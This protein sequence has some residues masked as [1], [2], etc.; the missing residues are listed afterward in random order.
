MV[1]KR[2]V[3][4]GAAA[5]LAFGTLE[6]LLYYYFSLGRLLSFCSP[7]TRPCDFSFFR[8]T[9]LHLPPPI[10][11]AFALRCSKF[12]QSSLCHE[13]ERACRKL[14]N[15]RSR[16][17]QIYTPRTRPSQPASEQPPPPHAARFFLCPRTNR[18][19][20]VESDVLD[21]LAR[22]RTL[23]LLLK[24]SRPTFYINL[25]GRTEPAL[26]NELYPSWCRTKP[27]PATE[28]F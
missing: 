25:A 14:N 24:R 27:T 8:F 19:W 17:L 2:K 23:A 18:I 22:A 15:S 10:R 5:P 4:F 20:R 26:D 28:A 7:P 12:C 13:Q 1:C 21:K 16:Y 9:R 6:R 11:T 3:V